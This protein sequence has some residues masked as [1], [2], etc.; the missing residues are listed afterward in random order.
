MTSEREVRVQTT[1]ELCKYT[2]LCI[3]E[4]QNFGDT[5][6]LLEPLLPI[7]LVSRAGLDGEGRAYNLEG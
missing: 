5:F 4:D 2:F 3:Y 7:P 1:G 6:V